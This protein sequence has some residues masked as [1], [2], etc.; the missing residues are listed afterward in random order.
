MRLGRRARRKKK[1]KMQTDETTATSTMALRARARYAV[2]VNDVKGLRAALADPALPRDGALRRSLIAEF[3]DSQHNPRLQMLALLFESLTGDDADGAWSGLLSSM[4]SRDLPWERPLVAAL[5]ARGVR[6]GESAGL[7]PLLRA[8]FFTL[9]ERIA[10]ADR[11]IEHGALFP[12]GPFTLVSLFEY[13]PGN[14]IVPLLRWLV[15]SPVADRIAPPT[16][17]ALLDHLI[18]HPPPSTQGRVAV[19]DMLLTDRRLPYSYSPSG[20]ISGWGRP[21]IQ[22]LLDEAQRWRAVHDE[23]ERALAAH[24]VLAG[25]FPHIPELVG[26]IGGPMVGREAPAAIARARASLARRSGDY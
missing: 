12:P 20:T 4:L 26:E 23:R 22:E 14:D 7:V 25:L 19:A 21:D 6:C 15:A 8:N 11:L 24:Q 9:R 3:R 10:R 18:A 13:I 17:A 2:T 5:L 1:K 16:W